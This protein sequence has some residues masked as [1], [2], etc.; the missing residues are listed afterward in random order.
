[1]SKLL[2]NPEYDT[3]EVF[4][5]RAYVSGVSAKVLLSAIITSSLVHLL[6]TFL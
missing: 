3:A 5:M 4:S 1:M 2:T 6:L